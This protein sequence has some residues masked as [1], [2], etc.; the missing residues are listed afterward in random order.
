MHPWFQLPAS[1]PALAERSPGAVLLHTALPDSASPFSRLFLSP[2][3]I[4]TA[5]TP[6]DLPTLFAAIEDAVAAGHLA[7]GF[8]SYECGAAFEPTVPPATPAATPLAWFGFYDHCHLFDHRTGRFLG[9]DPP[10]LAPTETTTAEI[11]PGP[12]PDPQAFAAAI[13]T[14]HNWIRAGDIYQLNYTWPLSLRTDANPATLYTHLIAQQPVPYAAFLHWQ[15]G[16]HILSLS[17]ELFFRIDHDGE[18]RSIVTRPMK[19]TAPRGRTTAEDATQAQALRTSPKNR[20]E[21]VMIVDLLR[22]DLGR[23]C[24]FGSVRVDSLFAVE[25]H[26]T[27]WQM[28]STVS[29][30]LRPEVGFHQ[31]FRA[32]FPS[33]SVTG[34]PKVRAMQ[35]IAQLE[36]RPRGIYTGAIGYFSRQTTVF[37]VA[38]RTLELEGHRAVMGV[39]SGIVIDSRADDELAEC[40]LKTQFLTHATEPFSLIETL[41]WHSGFPLLDLHLDRLA[42]SA[43]YFDFPFDRTHTAEALHRAT[44]ALPPAPRRVRLLLHAHGTLDITHEPLPTPS[45]DPVRVTISAELTD[46]ADRFLYHKTTHRP[47][48]TRAF[49]AASAAGFADVLFFNTRDELTEGAIGNVFLELDGRWVTPPI[50]SGLLPGVYRRHLLATRPEIEERILTRDDLAC[51]SAIWLANAVRGLRRATVG[52][53]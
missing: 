18:T 38:I 41:L 36:A 26:P 46:P 30:A 28:T 19:G 16:Q 50:S 13:H 45:A 44:A 12:T 21:N 25:R 40:L 6:S 20:A 10:G 23:L 48:Y 52:P 5:R 27:L 32:L 53:A 3:Q 17:P 34:A 11:H 39:G 2:T 47:L 22:N 42:D 15:P 8:F 29:G 9:T 1:V 24:S 7:A 35:L 14:I 49:A 4:I 33:G 51:A 43:S 37:N 31:I